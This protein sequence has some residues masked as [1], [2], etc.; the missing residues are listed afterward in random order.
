MDHLFTGAT[1]ALSV[2]S[3]LAVAYSLRILLHT[4]YEVRQF[5][6]LHPFTTSSTAMAPV[7]PEHFILGL[8][9]ITVPGLK[10]LLAPP[11]DEIV[12]SV[13]ATGP[14]ESQHEAAITARRGEEE[15]T[16]RIDLN[17]R[18]DLAPLIDALLGRAPSAKLKEPSIGG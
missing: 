11:P 13:T 8:M 18:K 3:L 14:P 16:V 10:E 5:G 2:L 4:R 12:V 17:Q 15:E 1:I 7:D 6:P 9:G